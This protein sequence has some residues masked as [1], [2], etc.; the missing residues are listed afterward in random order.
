MADIHDD[1]ME[2]I[3]TIAYNW[4]DA[5]IHLK[6]NNLIKMFFLLTE[7]LD[8]PVYYSQQELNDLYG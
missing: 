5:P 6:T 8:I 2:M 4:A 3:K 7:D 1:T